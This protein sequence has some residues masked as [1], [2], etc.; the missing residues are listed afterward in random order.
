MLVTSAGWAGV[1]KKD[2]QKLPPTY[3][4]WLTRDVAYIATDEEK[5]AFVR[6]TT[7]A[8]RDKFIERFWEIRNPNP[9]SPTN[10][11]KEEIYRRIAYANQ[12]FGQGGL[13]GWRTDRGRVYITLG[14]P[15]QVG[16]YLGFA[17][18]R[19]MEIWFYSNDHPALPPFFY[20]LFYEREDSDEF[21]LYSPFMDGP[22]KLVTGGGFEN[23]NVSAW[24]QIDHDA[25]RE[26]SRTTLSLI[27]SEPV[28]MDTAT[29]S[30]ASD[31]LLNNIRNL[32]NHPLNKEMLRQRRNLLEAVSHRVIL[33][34]EYLDVLTVPLVAP[35][36][37]TNLHYVLRLKR[38][39][40]F[41]VREDEKHRYYYSAVATARVSTPAGRLI[42]RQERKLSQYVDDKQYIRVKNRV[43]GYEGL[44]PLPPGKYK[45]EFQLADDLQH[46][47]FRAEREVVVPDRPAGGLRITEVVPFTEAASGQPPYMPFSAAGVRFTPAM[48]GLTLNPGHDLQFFY[49]LWAPASESN[50]ANDGNLQVEYAYGRMGMHDTQ[51]LK[52]EVS[53]AQFDSNGTLI[54][55]KRIPTDKLPPGDYRMAIT[56][57]DPA[58]HGRSVASF[59]FRVT[60]G[61]ASPP[62]WD[63]SDP[64]A[65]ED[66]Q[67]GMREYQRA[68]CYSLAGNQRQAITYLDRAYSKDHEE[69]T[70]DKLIDLLYSDQAFGRVAELYQQG[71]VSPQT[72]EQTILEM[73]ESLNRLGQVGKSI[74]L[75]ESALPGRQSSALYLGLSRYYQAAGDTQKASQ[76]EQK[77][78]TMTAAQPTT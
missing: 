77:A 26:V 60:D 51:T 23:D 22:Q 3:R 67:K 27:P 12:W 76:M 75:L 7:D 15:Q 18:I 49:Q 34:A 58:T 56:V 78:K 29:S 57:T 10:S 4:E 2:L 25:G 37:E 32:A 68:L 14:K 6:L 71:G 38:P 61:Q 21:R 69:R 73:A 52:E 35:S 65:A 53:R 72:D 43:F 63:I 47:S 50:A 11:Y 55:G 20:V 13:E 24:K 46:T 48:E 62:V 41:S 9:G 17:N 30:L 74:Q 16:K 66:V 64:E 33:G 1:S 36:G 31:M 70:R 54:N 28:D 59:Q 45:V 42:F 44:L 8:E 5:A 19:P 39:A 40:D